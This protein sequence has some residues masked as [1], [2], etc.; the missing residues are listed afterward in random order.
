MKGHISVYQ[1]FSGPI[2]YLYNAAYEDG[3]HFDID[4]DAVQIIAQE[5]YRLLMRELVSI[6]PFMSNAC[7][8]VVEMK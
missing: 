5:S 3:K 6:R 8:F 7:G 2:L 1:E 4:N